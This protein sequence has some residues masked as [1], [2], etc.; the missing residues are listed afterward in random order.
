MRKVLFRSLKPRLKLSP[1]QM[2]R[3]ETIHLA[4]QTHLRKQRE[5][6][7]LSLERQYN[8]MREACEELKKCS[9]RLYHAAVN[10]NVDNYPLDLRI[11][12]DTP[13]KPAWNYQ[14]S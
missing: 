4:W 10:A 3:H 2:M 14:K 5:E 8:K 7:R 11:P 12:T 9:G 6:R 1:Q 13:P